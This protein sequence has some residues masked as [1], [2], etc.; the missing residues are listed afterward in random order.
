MS[1]QISANIFNVTKISLNY[2]IKSKQ[3]F[4]YFVLKN[5]SSEAMKTK[6]QLDLQLFQ[7]K[8]I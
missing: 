6:S 2:F 5:N 1:L 8:I 3:L 7:I 4:N